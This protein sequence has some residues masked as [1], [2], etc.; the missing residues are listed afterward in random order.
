MP[1]G[2]VV[3]YFVSIPQVLVLFPGWARSAHLFSGPINEYQA[4]LGIKTLGVSLQTE[5][6][7]WTSAH[8]PQRVRVT[9]T[10]MGPVGTGPHGLL[11][12]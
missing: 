3:A 11:H 8:A 12:H 10:G 1:N 7:I 5:P 9:Y 4:S 6:L 2:R